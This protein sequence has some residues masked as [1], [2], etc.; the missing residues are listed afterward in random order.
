MRSW[1]WNPILIDLDEGN[2]EK[3]DISAKGIIEAGVKLHKKY[4]TFKGEPL[5]NNLLVI[6]LGPFARSPFYGTNRMTAVFR[7][8]MTY[9]LHVS[10]A[11]GVGFDFVRSGTS[12]IALKGK[13]KPSVIVIEGDTEGVHDVKIVNVDPSEVFNYSMLW[14]TYAISRYL[15]DTYGPGRGIAVGPFALRSPT[16]SLVSL[17]LAHGHPTPWSVDLF[18]RGGPGSVMAQA[19]GVLAIYGIGNYEPPEISPELPERLAN[20]LLN[21]PYVRAVLEATT[22][23][24]Y[25]PKLGTGGTF[26]VNYVHYRD[27]IPM[28][29]F[30]TMYYPED[31]R[32]TLSNMALKYFWKPFQEETIARR[33]WGTCGEPCPAACK[34][35]W[36]GTKIDYEPANALGTLLGIF[37]LEFARELIE[38]VDRAGMDAIEVGHEISWVFELLRRGLL[39]PEEINV[40]DIP[41][42]DPTKFNP[43]EDSEKNYEIA[44]SILEQLIKGGSEIIDAIANKGIRLAAKEFDKRYEKRVKSAGLKFEDL[45]IYVAFGEK[46]Y[47][48]PNLYWAPGMV[49]PLYVLGRYWTNYTPTFADPKSFAESS[50]RRAI[51][52]L[53]IDNSGICRFHRRWAEK[54]LPKMYEEVYESPV[55][56]EYARSIYKEIAIYNKKAGAEPVPWETK[57]TYDLVATMAENM[58]SEWAEKFRRGEGIAWW[59]EFKQRVDELIGL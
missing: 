25:D 8:P 17:G 28:L 19:H 9:G 1:P 56:E 54:L 6:G 46:G 50:F 11:G 41:N 57:K 33:Q 45:A 49:A 38:V 10:A 43:L 27:L 18:G 39:K 48:T 7:S 24:R 21:K 4:E 55:D 14:G 22:K 51:K 5:E 52:E 47:I 36:R 58:G 37:D 53:L 13:G 30:N 2:W 32:I 12:L 34:K 31:V 35:V 16:A 3:L 23:Y 15:Y 26:G 29:A 44:K 40:N 42:L 20:E 59:K